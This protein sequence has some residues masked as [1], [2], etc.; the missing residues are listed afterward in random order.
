MEID[1]AMKNVVC[2][3]SRHPITKRAKIVAEMDFSGRLN[4]G[5]D[6]GHVITLVQTIE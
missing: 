3:L 4:A 1:D 2:V 6:S 5:K